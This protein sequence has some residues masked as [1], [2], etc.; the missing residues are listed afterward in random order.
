M[1]I[2]RAQAVRAAEQILF[3]RGETDSATLMSRVVER[4]YRR[5][6]ECPLT[7]GFQPSRVVVY[8]GTGNNA[9]DAVGLAVRFGV[10]VLFRCVGEGHALSAETQQQFHPGLCRFAEEPPAPAAHTLVI[11]GL[12]G[13]GAKGAL[14]PAYEA[15]V[16][17][18]NALRATCP[19]SLLLAVDI[20]TGLDSDTGLAESV[21]VQADITAVIGG[22]KPGLT[23]DGAEDFVGRLVTV[24]L[25]EAEIEPAE[26]A[27]V[28]DRAEVA[29]WLPRRAASCFKNR[30]GRV[31]VVA[32]SP[33]MTGAARLCAE[34]ALAAGAGLVCL[35]CLPECY[36]IVAAS[37]APEVMVRRVTRYA[38]I[39]ESDARALLI[40]PGLG[41]VSAENAAALRQLAM[42]FP[43]TV[44][45]DADGLNLAAREGWD[46]P[47]RRFILTPHPGEIRR[48][49]PQGA[50]LS[51]RETVRLFLQ[52]HDCTLLFKGAR[53]LTADREHAWFNS[54]GGSYMANG[55][56]GDVLSGVIAALAAQGLSPLRAAVL[57]AY[58]C[59]CAAEAAC[60]AHGFARAVRASEVTAHLP[61]VLGHV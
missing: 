2:A 58:S 48:L 8:A 39:E 52:R 38:D 45:L 26:E 16:R 19:H 25:P 1:Q 12:L 44:V 13:S 28:T 54:S 11:D 14:R 35:Y 36:D 29:D 21:A 10:P 33:G 32:G 41:A 50:G 47:Q 43:H 27:R 7:A 4:L 3:A 46:F 40:G 23:A 56:Q 17:E 24:P 53:T 18:M 6:R 22:V 60:A 9:G 34:S 61:A 30:A 57:G 51:R 49:L 37:A 59:G 15:L 55:G 5:W 42:S 31:A 20:P